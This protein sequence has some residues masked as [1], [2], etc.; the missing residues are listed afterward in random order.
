MKK[1]L[2]KSEVHKH[3]RK[4]LDIPLGE[5]TNQLNV[6]NQ[7]NSVG[8]IFEEWFGKKKDSAS[9]PDLSDVGIELKATPYKILKNGN[10]SAK[11]RLVL[12]I[13]NYMD[14]VDENFE[15]SHF[16][17]KN[18]VIEIAFYEYLSKTPRNFWTISEVILYEM[19]KN[20]KDFVIIQQDWELI[21]RYVRQ[22]R[23]DELSESLT[24]YLSACT[25]GKSANTMRIQPYSDKLAKQRAFSLKSGYM[26]FLLRNYIFGDEYV[27]SIIKD[28]NELNKKSLNDIILDKFTMY[29]DMPIHQLLNLFNISSTSKQLLYQ[30]AAA[31]LG[32]SKDKAKRNFDFVEEFNKAAMILKTVKFDAG[33]HNKE[34]MSFPAFKF[35]EIVEEEWNDDDGNPS[36]SFH[37]LLLD[38]TFILFVVQTDIEGVDVFKGIKF[39][40]V[41]SEDIEGDIQ[42]VWEDTVQKL[43]QGVVLNGKRG[44]NGYRITNNFIKKSDDLIVH[45]RPHSQLSG[46]N[47]LK[48]DADLLP[49]RARWI[50]KPDS[51]YSD[52]WMTKQSF[53]FN[54]DYIKKQVQE[55]LI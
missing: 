49:S 36:A 18:S 32:L 1:Y 14:I 35:T 3:A 51:S 37:N 23:A 10:Y 54:N 46:Y 43:R 31:I 13:I 22:G 12:N 45:V 21:Q 4:I 53:W 6:S 8:D 19:S 39:F 52:Y 25:K 41:S 27:E 50:N 47:A 9:K 44:V 2:T 11:E 26:T 5:I 40:N 55:L 16:L 20:S 29:Q 30:L 24:T 33:G 38:S 48:P 42:Y 7:K 28:P 15:D 34:S 17:F